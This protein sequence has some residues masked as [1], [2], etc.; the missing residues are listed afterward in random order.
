MELLVSSMYLGKI[1][2]FALI[3]VTETTGIFRGIVPASLN[4]ARLLGGISNTAI[5]VSLEGHFRCSN[6]GL[7]CY[8]LFVVRGQ[9][10][11]AYIIDT[12]NR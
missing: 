6:S 2:W 8:I 4:T 12:L 1:A 11:P 9:I 7:Q 10:I 3:E 5:L